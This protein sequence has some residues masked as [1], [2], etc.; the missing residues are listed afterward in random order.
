MTP[1]AKNLKLTGIVALFAGLAVLIAGIVFAV[2]SFDAIDAM[3]MCS[4]ASGLLLGAKGARAA[5]VPSSAGK[6]VVPAAGVAVASAVM[7]GGVAYFGL[8][9][10]AAIQLGCIAAVAVLGVVIAFSARRIV[11][12]LER[13]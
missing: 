1:E 8:G 13:K 12:A 7:A 4:G 3:Q 9:G 6:I 5:N 10:T 11:R 2:M